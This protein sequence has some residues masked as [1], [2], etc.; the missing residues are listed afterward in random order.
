[1]TAK[2]VR[3]VLLAL[4]LVAIMFLFVFPTRSYLSQRGAVDDARN[5]VKVIQEQIFLLQEE[6]A[7]LQTPAEIERQARLQFNMVFP[8]EKPFA[9]VPDTSA[10]ADASDENESSP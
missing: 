6:S 3:I 1:M 9:V 2:T 8:G 7:R 5:D 4:L 10:E